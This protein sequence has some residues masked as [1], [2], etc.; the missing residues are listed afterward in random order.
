MTRLTLYKIAFFLSIVT[1]ITGLA[2]KIM[3]IPVGQILI[4]L[5]LGFTM[6][7]VL[8]AIYEIYKSDRITP[9]EKIMW[10]AGFILIS[11]VP[12]LLYLIMGRP[13]IVGEFRILDQQPE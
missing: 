6:V 2:A 7:Y 12:G 4:L 11:T 13:R 3:H 9:D 8:I 10:T 1:G 5:S